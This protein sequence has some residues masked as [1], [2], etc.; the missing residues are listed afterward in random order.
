MSD[1]ATTITA[2]PPYIT[3][4]QQCTLEIC[5]L[6]Y[7]HTTYLPNLGG[8]A[9][10]VAVFAL[11]IPI[12][13]YLG[14]RTR[15]WGYMVGMVCGLI[16]EV[17]GYIG[18]IKMRDNPFIDRWFEMYI[19]SLTIAPAFLSAAIYL[20]LARIVSVYSIELTRIKQRGYTL[21]F[22]TC[23]IFSLLLQ[24]AGGA[25]T[26]SN[27]NS[28]VQAGI[29]I[30]IAGLSTQVASLT[31]YLGICLDF[32]FRVY[33]LNSQKQSGH[34]FRLVG[35][36]HSSAL[37]NDEEHE[38]DHGHAATGLNP[39]FA[40]LRTSRKWHIFLVCQGL[41]TICIYIRCIFRV[42][43]LSGGFNGHLANDEVTFMVLEGAMITIATAA[44]SFWGHPGIGFAG[45]WDELNYPLFSKK[46]RANSA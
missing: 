44:L 5:P 12:Q 8:N 35:K 46:K 24:A 26:T 15:T 28:T 19:I 1:P 20:S 34:M 2:P 23:D 39:D 22:V 32:A 18:R 33:R 13:I 43:E 29:N 36:R 25:I 16:L 6:S 3:S 21:I 14:V 31:L 37:S 40:S 41:A 10:F 9:F 7:A 11:F 4:S 38:D 17:L 30:M 45:R 27:D 42:A